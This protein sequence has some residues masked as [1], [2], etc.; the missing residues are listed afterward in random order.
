MRP[1]GRIPLITAVVGLTF[2]GD[3]LAHIILALTTPTATYLALS[4]LVTIA[5]LGGGAGFLAWM[6]PRSDSLASS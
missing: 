2:F 6:R 5:I 3:A 1:A 4:H